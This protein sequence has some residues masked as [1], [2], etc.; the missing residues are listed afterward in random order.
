MLEVSGLSL[1]SR[2]TNVNLRL[3]AGQMVGVI[4]ANGAGKSTLLKLLAGLLTPSSGGS[5]W[6][7]IDLHHINPSQRRQQLAYIAQQTLVNEAV[8]VAYALQVSQVNL[9]QTKSQL[10]HYRQQTSAEFGLTE[11]LQRPVTELSGGE[12]KRVQLACGLIGQQPLILADEPI[13]SL[14]LRHQ[15][16]T[17]MLLKQRAEHGALV[18]VALHDLAL[19]AR[20]CQQLVLLHQG[21]LLAVGE[22]AEVLSKSLLQQAYQV[23][24]E[25]VCHQHGVA[26]LPRLLTD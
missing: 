20:F 17:L 2:L 11:L 6:Q 3:S 7:Q 16:E 26:M 9:A 18:L 1:E 14:D 5:V 22:P 19:A 13:A 23:E 25:W 24:V 21:Q 10:R 8:T 4:G 15:L 12:L